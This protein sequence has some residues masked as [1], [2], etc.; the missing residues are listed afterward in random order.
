[1]SDP[2]SNTLL[3][4]KQL[5]FAAHSTAHAFARAYRPLLAPLGLT[6]PQYLV[7]LLLWERDNRSVSDLGAA[8]FLDSGTLT[9][10]LKRMETAGLI[11][12]S[13]SPAD[14]RVVE[15]SLTDDGT[16]LQQQALG[17]PDQMLCRTGLT[18]DDLTALR[19][20]LQKLGSNLREHE[21]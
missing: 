13:R 11:R 8:L 9:P 20:A 1:M 21:E 6:Y 10:L 2:A 16:A 17:I 5:C 15:I 3:L 14:E 19:T 18:L 7:M 4:N 12:R